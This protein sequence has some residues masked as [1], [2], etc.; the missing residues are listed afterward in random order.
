MLT[1]IICPGEEN[2][3][4]LSYLV[5]ITKQLKIPV[6]LRFSIDINLTIK[7]EGL[8][9]SALLTY[10]TDLLILFSLQVH[11]GLFGSGFPVEVPD[12]PP[13]FDQQGT[14]TSLLRLA[15]RHLCN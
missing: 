6:A 3:V 11:H 4:Q 7:A 14:R 13:R 15:I 12:L 8:P 1:A 9:H 10:I 2:L 5:S